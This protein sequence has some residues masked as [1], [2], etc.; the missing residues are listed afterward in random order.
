MQTLEEQE[1][2]AREGSLVNK[3]IRVIIV[4]ADRLV[5]IFYFILVNK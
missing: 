1:G 5:G 4:N 2:G 3:V